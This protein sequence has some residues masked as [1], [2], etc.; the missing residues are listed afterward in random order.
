M[1][2]R[3]FIQYSGIGVLGCSVTVAKAQLTPAQTEGPFFPQVKPLDTDADLTKIA[4]DSALGEAV[5]IE[6]KV[7]DEK[8]QPITDA[9]VYI[10]QACASGRYSHTE[11]TNPAELDPN[12]QYSAQLR[13]DKTG[14]VKIKTVVPGAYPASRKWMRPAHIH[15]R[16]DT[17]NQGSLTTQMYFKGDKYI[18]TDHILRET[19]SLHG[20]EAHD[21]LIVDFDTQKSKDGLRMGLF[22]VVMA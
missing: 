12:F 10:W 17:Q 9:V 3:E 7:V 16:I 22:T 14:T 18:A 5:L 20:K 15:F 2:R 6:V 21:Q 8:H 1:R 11:D 4:V 13:T 19:K